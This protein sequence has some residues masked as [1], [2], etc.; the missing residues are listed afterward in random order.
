M[1]HGF[2]LN[3]LLTSDIV[4]GLALNFSANKIEIA[5]SVYS[6]A[7]CHGYSTIYKYRKSYH[8]VMEKAMIKKKEDH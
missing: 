1:I 2:V 4:F 6:G 7:N 5:C 3:A 8:V